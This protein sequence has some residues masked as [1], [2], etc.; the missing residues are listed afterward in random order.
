MMWDSLDVMEMVHNDSTATRMWSV[1]NASAKH[2][3][4]VTWAAVETVSIVTR[5]F[6]SKGSLK[7]I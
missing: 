3:W 2:D 5:S 4:S 7:L 6:S 1:S